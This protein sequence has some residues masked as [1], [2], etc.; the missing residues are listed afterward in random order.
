MNDRHEHWNDVYGAREETALTWFEAIPTV[1]LELIRKFAD[2]NDPILDVG[3]GASRIVDSLIDL[4][5][6]RISIL[7]LSEAGMN[8]SR[9]R[10]GSRADKVTWITEDV[11]KWVPDQPCRPWHDRA[12]F[13]FLTSKDDCRAYVSRMLSALEPSGIAI[14]MTFAE[15]GPEMCSGLPVMRYS[16]EDLV[17]TLEE[18]APGALKTVDMRKHV[19]M[20]PKG[21]EQRFQV[22]VLRKAGQ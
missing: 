10:L 9:C 20:T 19:H 2:A 18:I 6:S 13:H 8:V 21:N 5:F 15:D 1:S 22:S 17:A 14:I 11:T 7:D 12:V 3:G 4:G 16:P